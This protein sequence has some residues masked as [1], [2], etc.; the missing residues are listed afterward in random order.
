MLP[1]LC[2]LSAM[3]GVLLLSEYLWRKCGLR[4]EYGRKFV[5]IVVGTFVAISPF[6]LSKTSITILAILSLLGML[7]S[8][9]TNLLKAIHDVKRITVGEFAAPLGVG[10]TIWLAR[11]PWVFTTALLFV[12]LADGM[13]AIVGKKWGKVR[14]PLR[15]FGLRKT[16]EGSTAYVVMA[17]ISVALGA[18]LGGHDAIFL[19]PIAAFAVMPLVSAGIEAVSP[20]GIDN[21][22]VPLFVVVVL[23][24]LVI[25][26]G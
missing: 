3:I 24:L 19:A 5:H 20:Y 22:T 9:Y 11:E 14:L 25:A 10:I 7:V 18:L 1:L 4:D 8:R 21:I 16:L 12:A 13:A 2:A 6:F 23:N 15:V 26:K 17:V